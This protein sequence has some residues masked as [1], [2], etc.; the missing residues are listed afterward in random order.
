MPWNFDEANVAFGLF[1]YMTEAEQG[2]GSE[3]HA[4]CVI[5]SARMSEKIELLN[6]FNMNK[7]KH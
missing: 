7:V 5:T 1:I 3:Y 6:H 4:L 2:T